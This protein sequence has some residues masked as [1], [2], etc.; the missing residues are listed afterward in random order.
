MRIRMSVICFV[1]ASLVRVAAAEAQPAPACRFPELERLNSYA[2]VWDVRL[3]SRLAAAGPWESTTGVADVSAELSGCVSI[4]RLRTTRQG[5]SMEAI[6]VLTW[7]HQTS[8]WQATWTDSEHGMQL[9]YE[10]VANGDVLDLRLTR[11]VG[12]RALTLRRVFR[13]SGPDQF[14]TESA[15]LTEAGAWDVTGRAQYSK[16]R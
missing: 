14:S 11:Q 13:F 6:T 1:L 2:G 9:L 16:R 3:E 15:R 8:R 7:D 5:R 4:E 10:G 12:N